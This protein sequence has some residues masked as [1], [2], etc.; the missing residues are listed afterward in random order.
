VIG[1]RVGSGFK[2]KAGLGIIRQFLSPINGGLM[3]I[4]ACIVVGGLIVAST[5]FALFVASGPEVT[6]SHIARQMD[7][8]HGS[9]T[10]DEL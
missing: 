2:T 4:V 8:M 10:H 7:K 6:L 9:Q 3:F 5:V 1:A